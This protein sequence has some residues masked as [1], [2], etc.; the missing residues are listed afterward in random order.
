MT[1]TREYLED[2]RLSEGFTQEFKNVF[3]N[4]GNKVF[5]DEKITLAEEQFVCG[6]IETLKDKNDQIAHDIRNYKSCQNYRFRNRY[7]LYFNDLNGYKPVV[8]SKGE[9]SKESKAIDVAFLEDEYQKWSELIQNKTT[10]NEIINYVA[11][12]TK[13]QIKE[14]EAYCEGLMIGANRKEYLQKSLT[15]HG[16]YIF[17]L[18]SEFYQELGKK[19]IIIE[20]NNK[21]VLI[22]G[23]TYIHTL[24]RHFAE[25][26][27]E[28]QLTKSYHFDQSV[29][30]KTIPNLLSEAILGYKSLTESIDFDYN[31]INFTF[32]KKVYAIWFRP[33]SKY[34]K[35]VGKVEYLRVQTFYPI[36]LQRDLEKLADTMEVESTSGFIY[37]IKN[38]I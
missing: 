10:G 19:E 4:L 22:N 26:I 1:Y 8:N 35:K 18:V 28:H 15:L 27:K 37:H 20:L 36:G 21:K 32:N 12:E 23:F 17:I 9:M 16:K 24:F 38:A 5:A 6:L 14:L 30:F 25:G 7:L 33:F 34:E 3:E 29:G 2:L 31:N 11:Q 13:Q